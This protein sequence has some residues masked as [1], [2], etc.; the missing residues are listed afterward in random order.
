MI[1]NESDPPRF[2]FWLLRHMCPG[3]NLEALTGDLIER[4]RE[5]ASNSWFWRQ[6]LIA[7]TTSVLGQIRR[8]WAFFCY[9]AAGT[10]AM[11]VTRRYV[12]IPISVWLHWSDLPWPLSQFAFELSAPALITLSTLT[13]L[14]AGLLIQHSFRWNDVFRTWMIN[15]ALIA[16]GH[17]ATD[18]FPWLLR[19]IPGNPYG[20]VLIIPEAVQVLLLVITFVA[21][22]WLGCPMIERIGNSEAPG[23][24]LE[25]A[26]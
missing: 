21:A 17:Y 26:R 8:R 14:A 10:V 12:P 15:F 16:I 24:N 23:T 3:E 2:A 1:V 22:A 5:G 4:F 18:L 6:V 20:K 19:P 9:A 25:S 11:F 13:V 7:L